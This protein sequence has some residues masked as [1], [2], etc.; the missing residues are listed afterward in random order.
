MVWD[1]TVLL[2][3]NV[4]SI[5]L[6]VHVVNTTRHSEQETALWEPMTACYEWMINK[7]KKHEFIECK[8]IEADL[9]MTQ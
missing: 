2:L 6:S 3:M 5:E 1:N 4:S 8:A 9:T 7:C